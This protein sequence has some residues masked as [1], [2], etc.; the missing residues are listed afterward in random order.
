MTIS[1]CSLIVALLIPIVAC[2][3]NRV[4]VSQDQAR[5][6]CSDRTIRFA[7]TPRGVFGEFPGV[8]QVQDFYR[9]C[10]HAKAGVN[11][12]EKFVLNQTKVF[13]LNKV[14]RK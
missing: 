3:D 11:P 5:V 14:L 10:F 13:D 6:V 4:L 9:S 8:L 2:A 7:D 1:K 12:P